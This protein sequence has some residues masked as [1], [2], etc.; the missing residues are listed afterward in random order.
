MGH[1]GIIEVVGLS[2]LHGSGCSRCWV[3]NTRVGRSDV[4]NGSIKGNILRGR[5]DD[6]QVA[7]LTSSSLRFNCKGFVVDFAEQ[8][9]EGLG[10]WTAINEGEFA[11]GER[12]V[13]FCVSHDDSIETN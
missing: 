11:M 13:D 12:K 2:D 8:F 3:L 4:R 5:H 10:V 7:K 6:A 9:L 1:G